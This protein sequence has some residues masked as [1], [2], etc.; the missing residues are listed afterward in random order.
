MQEF[1]DEQYAEDARQSGN[2]RGYEGRYWCFT[3]HNPWPNASDMLQA[4]LT[5][6]TYLLFGHEICPRTKRPHL[7]GFVVFKNTHVF[8]KKNKKGQ[9][10]PDSLKG[11]IPWA[12]WKPMYSTPEKCITYCKKDGKFEEFGTP[13]KGQGH[14]SEL[15]EMGAVIL[16]GE[17]PI[18]EF[19]MRF[20][21]AMIR[22]PRGVRE[23]YS[24]L[25]TYGEGRPRSVWL[26]GRSGVGKT[27][28]AFSRYKREDIYIKADG[29]PFYMNYNQ[30][31][32]MVVDEYHPFSP[33]TPRGWD[34]KHI[35]Q[36]L[37]GYPLDLH[38]KGGQR[39]LNTGVIFITSVKH[40][41]EYIPQGEDAVQLYRR[42]D[43]IYHVLSEDE[44][45]RDEK[46]AQLFFNPEREKRITYT[47][48]LLEDIVANTRMKTVRRILAPQVARATSA[49]SSQEEDTRSYYSDE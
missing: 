49:P 4:G 18:E 38:V 2:T 8:G 26:Y 35:L 23:L 6:W 22:Y 27:G 43:M 44:L 37:S 9:Y 29:Q 42:L 7:Q 24:I 21:G 32:V 5:G 19:A 41:A 40:P 20:P 45:V 30:Q 34:W 11:C 33:L 47:D 3:W 17:T 36:L 16:A 10:H 48:P 1:D 14:R 39:K 31:P 12:W 46:N 28:F 13:P 25:E 15:E